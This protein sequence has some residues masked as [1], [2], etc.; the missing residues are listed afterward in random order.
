MIGYFLLGRERL[1]S[2]S[3]HEPPRP[4]A[5]RVTRA[6]ALEFIKDGFVFPAFV[7]PPLW[8]AARGIW[9]GTLAY[10]LAICCLAWR[11]MNSIATISQ[12]AAGTRSA[13]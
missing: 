6:E 11:P 8:L 12:H 1:R 7:L 3:V 2:Y 10:G 5:D 9:L 4:A 13:M